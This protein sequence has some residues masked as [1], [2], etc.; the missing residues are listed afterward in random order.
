MV[1]GI[2]RLTFGI[3]ACR[4]QEKTI[5]LEPS[6]EMGACF[7]ICFG[8]QRLIFGI[9]GLLVTPLFILRTAFRIILEDAR[10]KETQ[11]SK[12]LRWSEELKGSVSTLLAWVAD[13]PVYVAE[14]APT[15][16]WS[17][18]LFQYSYPQHFEAIQLKIPNEE[19]LTICMV[20]AR[21]ETYQRSSNMTV[22][23]V[24][25]M[26]NTASMSIFV[27]LACRI[28]YQWGANVVVANMRGHG[29]TGRISQDIPCS[30]TLREGKDIVEIGRYLK[31]EWGADQSIVLLGM[32]LGGTCALS[33]VLEDSKQHGNSL[34]FDACAMISSPMDIG[35]L[36]HRMST[37]KLTPES[38]NIWYAFYHWLLLRYASLR[39][40]SS[41]IRCFRSFVK[42]AVI[43]FYTPE[44]A[45]LIAEKA[46]PVHR[47]HFLKTPALAIYARDDPVTTL[48]ESSTLLQKSQKCR[49]DALLRMEICDHGGHAGHFA[50]NSTETSSLVHNFFLQSVDKKR[51]RT[52]DTRVLPN[53]LS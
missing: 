27:D 14:L 9:I 46:S 38:F 7:R 44:E 41:D 2:Q 6:L 34:L 21:H 17:S 25:G 12:V 50:I 10:G 36:M 31:R 5:G 1:L 42:H 4:M 35:G 40:L 45:A 24:P 3:I 20:A 39:G 52:K 33:A 15:H 19:N 49:K 16:S 11:P 29:D 51:I 32:S 37:M 48:R 8:F 26:F 53:T 43:P 13:V 28:Y 47:L 30:L 18:R 23:L 22:I